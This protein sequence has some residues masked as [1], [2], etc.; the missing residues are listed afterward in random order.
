MAALMSSS[1]IVTGR[2]FVARCPTARRTQVSS[3]TCAAFTL[4][5][6]PYAT[7]ALEPKISKA[8]LDIHW[9]KHHRTYV[10]NLNGQVEGTDMES[11]SLEEVMQQT[12]NNGS[13]EPAFNNA[14][15]AWNHEFYWESMSPKPVELKGGLKADI[16]STFGSVE[17]FNKE[18]S[19]AGATQFGSGWAWLV[20]DNG[21]LAIKK[22]PNAENPITSGSK[23]ILVMDVWEHAYYLDVQNKRPEYIS[24]FVNELINWDKVAERYSAAK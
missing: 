7:D 9:G 3:V 5:D 1:Q 20:V 12:W 15:Q 4:P 6:L 24:T 14:A 18:F 21:K 23:P 10:T 16:E 11:K 19:T 22:T 13:P 8:T 17:N 2:S